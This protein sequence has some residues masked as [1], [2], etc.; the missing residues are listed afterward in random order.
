MR[1]LLP[2]LLILSCLAMLLPGCEPKEELLTRDP[3][4]TLE[5]STDTVL[6]D[7]VFVQTGSV[8]KR[9]WVYNRNARAVRVEQISLANPGSTTYTVTV[10]GDVG[11]TARNVT[12]RGKDSLLVLVK[13]FIDPS[14]SE[15]KPFLVEEEL[16][17]ET[18]GNDQRVKLVAYGQN[19]YF[20]NAQRLCTQTWRSDKPHVIYNSVLVSRGCVLTI[21][22][23][24]RIYS[25]AG[26]AIIVQGTLLVN[27]VFQPGTTEVKPD[28]RNIVRFAADRRE[29]FYDEIP[30]QWQGIQFD[31]TS[32]RNNVVRY[33]EL[34]NA[35][36]GLLVYNPG[37]VTPHPRVTVENCVIKNISGALLS[38]ASGGQTFEGAGI[39]SFSGDFD[40][41]NTLF[42]NCGEYAVRGI[43]G[44]FDLDFCTVA[45]YTP[46][47]NRKTASLWFTNEPAVRRVPAPL[48]L[49]ISVTNS[50][51]WGSVADEL[52]F[53]NIGTSYQ[54][55]IRNS[56]LRTD[57]FKSVFGGNSNLLNIYPKFRRAP[58]TPAADKFDFRL[59]TLS[60]A[61][62]RPL[63]RPLAPNVQRDLRN[64]LRSATAP[65]LG[66]YERLNP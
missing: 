62:N 60:P 33:T 7:T 54:P 56:L 48:P 26:S 41:T 8:T 5:F 17:F 28:D 39:F 23:G 18:N 34:K 32:S 21:E 3:S 9:L 50:I 66:A 35:A 25:H 38:F 37:N 36:F 42:T 4:A 6:F 10:G 27:P 29:R 30:G 2:L 19:A 63:L 55:S 20:H 1:L 44:A 65:D 49:S 52:F 11:T 51:V 24:T 40:V 43:G 64:N 47:F 12:I 53:K 22:A 31:S 45:N 61:S 16:R 57:E 59:D 13:A 46:R 58:E 14:P 15:T